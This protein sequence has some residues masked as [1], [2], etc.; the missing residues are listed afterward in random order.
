MDSHADTTVCGANCTILSYTDKV[1]EVT[2]YTDAYDP[3]KDVPIVKAATA[4]T[5][6]ETGETSILVFNEAIWMGSTMNHTLVNP[7]QL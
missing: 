5:N 1:C 6:T 2:P 3:I 4:F 7:N